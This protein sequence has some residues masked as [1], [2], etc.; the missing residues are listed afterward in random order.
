MNVLINSSSVGK[1]EI[2]VSESWLQTEG[3][4]QIPAGGGR[5]GR[6]QANPATL[7][8]DLK[9][10]SSEQTSLFLSKFLVIRPAQAILL[11]V[12]M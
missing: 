2:Q 12:F 6:A 4:T 9:Q 11:F 1:I 10:V 8:L 7:I 3:S 5:R